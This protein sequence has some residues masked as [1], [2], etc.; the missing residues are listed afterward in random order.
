MLIGLTR[1]AR[2][3]QF[4]LNDN[5]TALLT[6]GGVAGT[7]ATAYLTGRATFKAARIIDREQR[8]IEAEKEVENPDWKR[9]KE[10]TR[11][12][13]SKLVW[14]LYI[15][16]F[17]IAVTTITCIIVANKIA[18]R[19]IAALAVASGISERA[20]QEYKSKVVEKLGERKDTEIRDQIAQER[21]N[22]HPASL[23]EV[24]IAG[25]GD[26][27]CYDMLTGRYF[28]STV[29]SIRQAENKINHDL[30][31]FMAAS[32]TEFYDELGLAATTVTDSLGWN[33]NNHVKVVFSSVLM[34]GRPCLAV[35]FEV[36]PTTEYARHYD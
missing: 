10:L 19:K 26:V 7:L 23:G 21:V 33:A 32:A 18:S 3:A 25:D 8:L 1:I 35:D 13:K 28:K 5:S 9:A 4:L 6:G 30:N 17:S 14:K 22:K 12:E 16:P 34:D 2:R 27:L 11:F 31:N 20:L 24:I 29:E 15:P 36:P